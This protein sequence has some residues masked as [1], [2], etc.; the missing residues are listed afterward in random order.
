MEVELFHYLGNGIIKLESRKPQSILCI[1]LVQMYAE[2]SQ[3]LRHIGVKLGHVI[4]SMI[5]DS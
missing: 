4:L 1:E 2:I 3:C 5:I